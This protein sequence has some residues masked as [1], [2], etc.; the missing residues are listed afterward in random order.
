MKRIFRAVALLLAAALLAGVS[1]MQRGKGQ[2]RYEMQFFDSF[3]TVTIITGSDCEG[4]GE[5]LD[6]KSVV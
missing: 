3:D 2:G 4:A 5:M 6:R 1:L